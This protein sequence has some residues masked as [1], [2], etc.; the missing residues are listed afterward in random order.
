M[1]AFCR[2]NDLIVYCDSV[3]SINMILSAVF[4]FTV[5]LLHV[6]LFCVY[7]VCAASVEINY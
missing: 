2:Y 1:A 4:I 7:L 5:F 6:V 3:L